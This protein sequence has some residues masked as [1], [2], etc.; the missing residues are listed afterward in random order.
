MKLLVVLCLIGFTCCF[1]GCTRSDNAGKNGDTI[2][3]TDHNTEDELRESLE[4]FEEFFVKTITDAADKLDSLK[5]SRRPDRSTLRMK[6]LFIRA[7]AAMLTQEEP[8]IALIDIWGLSA[9]FSGYYQDGHG[10]KSV[11]PNQ[12]VII[13]AARKI[14]SLIENIALKYLNKENFAKTRQKVH[15]F[16]DAN[17]IKP[18]MKETILFATKSYEGRS[19]PFEEI[20]TLPLMPLVMVNEVTDGVTGAGKISKSTDH[21]ADIVEGFPESA[22]WQLLMLLYDIEKLESVKSTLG[23]FSQ[24]SKSTSRLTSLV[25]Q[26][27]EKLR[28]E[29]SELMKEIEE[30]SQY[31]N[32]MLLLTA[33]ASDNIKEALKTGDELTMSINKTSEKIQ[34]AATAWQGAADSSAAAISRMIEL[35]GPDHTNVDMNVVRQAAVEINSIAEKIPEII[36]HADTLIGKIIGRIAFI[37]ILTFATIFAFT[38]F[39][40]RLSKRNP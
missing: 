22:R 28:L 10:S 6:S 31:I 38:F 19:N 12:S 33:D 16:A 5:K 23:S 37:I 18:A 30:K 7:S 9:R 24:F 20:I 21:I 39:V 3:Y 36:T 17:P 34:L 35:D 32:K 8:M 29:F 26:L 15:Q 25:D 14:E 27:P 2:S 1:L 4:N 11:Q 13:E 40:I